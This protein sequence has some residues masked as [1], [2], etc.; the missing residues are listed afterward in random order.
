MNAA[1]PIPAGS[2]PGRLCADSLLN[3]GHLRALG[4]RGAFL[5]E[6]TEEVREKCRRDVRTIP[7]TSK[8]AEQALKDVL[9]ALAELD[10]VEWIARIQR[11]AV[12]HG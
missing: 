3:H 6:M 11:K 1:I 4:E 9:E 8:A 10:A 5:R 12:S 7:A 2:L